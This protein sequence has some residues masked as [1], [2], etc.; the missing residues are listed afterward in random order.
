M[1]GNLAW[2]A[3][4]HPLILLGYVGL[5]AFF[6]AKVEIHIEG[7]H[8]WAEKLPT[9]RIENHWLLRVL[10]GGR[11]LTGYHA[12]MFS[13]MALFFLLPMF[14]SGRFTWPLLSRCVGSLLIFWTLEDFL[15]F[16]LNPAW[17]AYTFFRRE[18]PW[19]R[20]YV[21]GLPHD[22]WIHLTVGTILLW[23]SFR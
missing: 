14:L 18:V 10:W 22:Y 6:F 8:G 4:I 23:L 17:G 16:V 20:H 1:I 15:W 7:P 9:W 21:L 3:T 19:H 12:W 13:F 11:A 2:F 5:L